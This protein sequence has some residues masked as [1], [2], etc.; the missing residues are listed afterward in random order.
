M[1]FPSLF[2]LKYKDQND[3]VYWTSIAAMPTT[4]TTTADVQLTN[5]N[6]NRQYTFDSIYYDATGTNDDSFS[7]D[8]STNSIPLKSTVLHT[9]EVEKGVTEL[10]S[11]TTSNQ[12]LTST[13]IKVVVNNPD[14]ALSTADT[15]N[16]QY[17]KVSDS[18]QSYSLSANLVAEGDNFK[19]EFTNVTIDLNEEYILDRVWLNAKPGLALKNISENNVIYQ[20]TDN[21]NN[22]HKFMNKFKLDSLEIPSNESNRNVATVN[23]TLDF[24][25]NLQT[26]KKYRA[27]FIVNEDPNRIVWSN[28]VDATSLNDSSKNLTLNLSGLELNRS[29]KFVGLYWGETSSTEDNFLNTNDHLL[30]QGFSEEKKFENPHGDTK[31]SELTVSDHKLN[32]VDLKFKL[33]NPDNGFTNGTTVVM[34]YVKNSNQDN[35]LTSQPVALT[36][37]GD[38]YYATFDDFAIDLNTEYTIKKLKV[39]AKP[40]VLLHNVNKNDNNEINVTE[41]QNLDIVNKLKLASINNLNQQDTSTISVKLDQNNGLL[42]NK[43]FAAKYTLSSGEVVWTNVQAATPSSNETDKADLTLTLSDLISNRTYTF[44]DLYWTDNQ[45][46]TASDLTNLTDANK[47]VKENS[48]S[49]SFTI[50]FSDTRILSKLLTASTINSGNWEFTINDPDKLMTVG[51]IIVVGYLKE[52][53]PEGTT[54]TEKEAA[55]VQDGS[56]YKV[57]FENVPMD[58]NTKYLVKE[59]RLKTKT[60]EENPNINGRDNNAIYNSV[61]DSEEQSFINEFKLTSVSNNMSSGAAG[62]SEATITANFKATSNSIGADYKF[63]VKYVSADDENEVIISNSVSS[64]STSSLN[65]TLSNLNKNRNYRFVELLYTKDNT[66]ISSSNG[67]AFPIEG[68]VNDS[69]IIAHGSTTSSTVT[70]TVT[71]TSQNITSVEL[72]IMSEDNV[73]EV[74]Q[75]LTLTVGQKDNRSDQTDKTTVGTIVVRENKFYAI[76]NIEGLAANMDYKVY[77]LKFNDKPRK[78]HSDV[79]STDANIVAIPNEEITFK[80]SLEPHVEQ[81]SQITLSQVNERDNSIRGKEILEVAYNVEGSWSNVSLP[82]EL[83]DD[84]AENKGIIITYRGT[85]TLRNNNQ[86]TH[87]ITAYDVTYNTQTKLISFKLKGMKAGYSYNLNSVIFKQKENTSSINKTDKIIDTS[88]VNKNE[89]IAEG[90]GWEYLEFDSSYSYWPNANSAREDDTAKLGFRNGFESN[91]FTRLF[92]YI[93]YESPR[94]NQA[95]LG[96][97]QTLSNKWTTRLKEELTKAVNAANRPNKK[98][99]FGR[100]TLYGIQLGRKWENDANIFIDRMKGNNDPIN[101]FY[102]PQLGVTS[103]SSELGTGVMDENWKFA[104]ANSYLDAVDKILSVVNVF[105]IVPYD[106]INSETDNTGVFENEDQRRDSGYTMTNQASNNF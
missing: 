2:R 15:L 24:N 95:Y 62:V 23:A 65:F 9:F 104:N 94:D 103:P 76:F 32:S 1:I 8:S 21:N 44:V 98:P 68:T 77:E 102:K 58:V 43:Y 55:L 20:K 93:K 83:I 4:G 101:N 57:T 28:I 26:N 75:Q 78:A 49:N 69:F 59:L 88:S 37:E 50:A 46:A 84:T 35:T 29:Y 31:A 34:E 90:Y 14:N 18:S 71:A 106:Q 16:I 11:F 40:N 61:L 73:L 5:L 80:T 12:T 64:N 105:N 72:E 47:V 48:I 7:Q 60:K 82:V 96:T 66:D 91:D 97:N 6:K 19:V 39:T 36:L 25:N 63:A 81:G 45:N 79:Y 99:R 42:N 86:S 74:G 53:D 33:T 70:N 13:D 51:S 3:V 56:N 38:A 54:L 17:V 89:H 10:Q 41:L 22:N 52:S 85:A 87:E 92:K 30:K 100:G 67:A 27:K